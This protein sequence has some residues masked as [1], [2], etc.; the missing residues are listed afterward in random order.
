MLLDQ[1]WMSGRV[2]KV[3][4]FCFALRG[5]HTDYLGACFRS[6]S[7]S[8]LIRFPDVFTRSHVF[9]RGFESHLIQA[10]PLG[11]IF[12]CP[13]MSAAFDL[14]RQPLRRALGTS[15]LVS[16]IIVVCV[17]WGVLKASDVMQTKRQQWHGE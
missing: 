15:D 6:Y 7:K 2:V 8:R 4:D 12:G 17:C 5:R 11:G 10:S 14:P 9:G 13:A 16:K 1:N 3:R